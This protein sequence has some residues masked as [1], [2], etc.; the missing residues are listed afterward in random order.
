M[1]VSFSQYLLV[2]SRYLHYKVLYDTLIL[3]MPP[4]HDLENAKSQMRKGVLEFCILLITSKGPVYASEILQALLAAKLLV[5]EG[6]LY[7]LLNRLR[8]DDLLSYEWVESKNGPPRKYYAITSHGQA[9]LT[10]LRTSWSE[11]TL[12]VQTLDTH[13]AKN[14]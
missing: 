5:V 6:T 7:P 11:L 3:S 8:Q 13:Y 2:F 9:T 1:G 10:A 4:L 14:H 12:A